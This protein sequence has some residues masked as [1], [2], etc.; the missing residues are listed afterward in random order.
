M[1]PRNG[2]PF[3]GWYGE[4][5]EETIFPRGTLLSSSYDKSGLPLTLAERSVFV[6]YDSVLTHFQSS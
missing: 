5:T 3:S 1:L 2:F 4:G 6:Q